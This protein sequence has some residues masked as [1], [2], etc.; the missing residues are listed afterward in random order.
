MAPRLEIDSLGV[1]LLFAPA[2]FGPA[3]D[4][5]FGFRWAD[6]SWVTA[7]QLGSGTLSLWPV[8]APPGT[9]YL[10]WN[11]GDP[12]TADRLFFAHVL[13]SGVSPP[14]TVAYLGLEYR[15]E[16]SAAVSARRR[17]VA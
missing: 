2:I 11:G 13:P 5:A 6:S 16:Y 1:P 10:V 8:Q 15:E 17:W 9:H 3:G 14:E 7:W 12:E 4:D